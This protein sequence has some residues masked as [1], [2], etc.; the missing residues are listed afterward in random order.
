MIL[1]LRHF[2]PV[3]VKGKLYNRVLKSSKFLRSGVLLFTLHFT[4][5]PA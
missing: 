5:R 2:L 3:A 1:S 4:T